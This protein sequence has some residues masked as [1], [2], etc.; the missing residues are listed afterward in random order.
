MTHTI[1]QDQRIT[2]G[3]GHAWN[4]TL[5]ATPGVGTWNVKATLTRPGRTKERHGRWSARTGWTKNMWHP[6]P[7]SLI[8]QIAEEWMK[9]H[10]VP[11]SGGVAVSRGR[12]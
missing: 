6:L 7:G 2:W 5:Q 10:P 9:T 12:L 3:D 11:I 1:C 4:L 8:A